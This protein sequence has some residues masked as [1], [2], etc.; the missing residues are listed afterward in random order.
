MGHFWVQIN[1]PIFAGI[2]DWSITVARQYVRICAEVFR[3]YGLINKSRS[4]YC[5]GAGVAI[6]KQQHINNQSLLENSFLENDHGDRIC[7][8]DIAEHSLSN[9]AVRRA[10]RMTRIRGFDEIA[11]LN[12]DCGEFYT[13]TCPSRMHSHSVY[14]RRNPK[15]DGTTTAEC[16]HNGVAAPLYGD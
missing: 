4:I 7:L 8:A 11:K 15:F 12:N 2:P 1:T 14:G 10:E 5:S 9:P 3:A 6:R 13:F 16:Q